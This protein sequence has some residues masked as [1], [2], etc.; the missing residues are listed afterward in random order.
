MNGEQI[1][2]VMIGLGLA[3]AALGALVWMIGRFFPSFRPGRLPG[4]VVIE[5]PQGGFYFPIVTMILLSVFLSG[6]L[7]LFSLLRK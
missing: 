4:D 1:G 3:I 7:W 2:K 5:G 6:L